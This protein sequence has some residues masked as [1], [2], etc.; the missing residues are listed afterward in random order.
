MSGSLQVPLYGFVSQEGNVCLTDMQELR[1]EG[2]P[3]W[4]T[5]KKIKKKKEIIERKEIAGKVAL[6]TG[7]DSGISR[8]VCLCFVRE[9]ATV[10]F[11]YVKSQ[12]DKDAEDTLAML[13]K[14]KTPDAKDPTAI[15]ADLG[16]DKN[17]KTDVDEVVNAYGRIDILFNN[18]A[19]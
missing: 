15:S 11:T 4:S 5:C 7:G 6:V 14:D 18:A 13:R 19:E 2:V 10:A 16:F 3:T 17:C 12:E 1:L 9:G 8:A